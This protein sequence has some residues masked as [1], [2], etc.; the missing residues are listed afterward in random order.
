MFRKLSLFNR[1]ILRFIRVKKIDNYYHIK[2]KNGYE[3]VA[4]LKAEPINFSLKSDDEKEFIV[5]N[6]QKFINSLDFPIQISVYTDVLNLDNYL[7]NSENRINEKYKSIFNNYKEHL[8]K[9][10]ETKSIINRT[11]YICVKHEKEE[12]LE[13]Q[14]S[15][16]T[17]KLNNINIKVS[18]LENNELTNLLINFFKDNNKLYP[19]LILPKKIHNKPN[20]IKI[21]NTYNTC[22]Y[23]SGY[24]RKVEPGFLDRIITLNGAF[25]I[26]LFIEP[27]PI[28]ET[29]V[30]LNKELQKQRADLFSLKSKAILNPSLEIKYKDTKKI[31]E[32]LQKGNEKL[33]NVSLYINVKSDSLEELNLLTKKIEAELNSLKLTFF[34]EKVQKFRNLL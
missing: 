1:K 11:F 6:F 19:D 30:M 13:Q 25:H 27:S 8:Q 22:I 28:Q 9:T 16:L 31:L 12:I 29:M 14:L 23:A 26:S 2:K 3:K 18:R 32:E 17:E 4:V 33:F 24:P 5:Y 20:Y 10:I 21:N 34:D 7:E 15:V